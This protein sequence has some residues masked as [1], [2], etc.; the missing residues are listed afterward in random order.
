M[1]CNNANLNTPQIIGL[2]ISVCFEET[3]AN[4]LIS[5]VE[6]GNARITLFLYQ[7]AWPFVQNFS[8]KS[9]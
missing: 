7:F 2:G 8:L 5:G 6:R 9:C 4:K 1:V 3:Y